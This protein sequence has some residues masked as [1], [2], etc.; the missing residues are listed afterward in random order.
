MTPDVRTDFFNVQ[1]MPFSIT[2]MYCLSNYDYC[3]HHISSPSLFPPIFQPI[4]FGGLTIAPVTE[5]LLLPR[6]LPRTLLFPAPLIRHHVPNF[7]T[8]NNIMLI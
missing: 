3:R 5:N 1:L 2:L 4:L 7:R 6:I 8:I